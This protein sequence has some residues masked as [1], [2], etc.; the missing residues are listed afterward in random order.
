M[1]ALNHA[2]ASAMVHGPNAGLDLRTPLDDDERL[3]RHHRLECGA[4]S[5][6]RARRQSAAAVSL[7]RAAAEKTTSVPEQTT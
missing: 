2:I 7:Y 6:P 1:V 5:S 4:R 3:S